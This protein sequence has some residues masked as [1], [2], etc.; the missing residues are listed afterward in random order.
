M[1]HAV[2]LV[3][4]MFRFLIVSIHLAKNVHPKDAA[5][6]HAGDTSSSAIFFVGRSSI[7]ASASAI[8]SS[9]EP[10]NSRASCVRSSSE[11]LYPEHKATPQIVRRSFSGRTVPSNNQDG[12]GRNAPCPP[13]TLSGQIER[14]RDGYARSVLER[15][16]SAVSGIAH[17]ANDPPVDSR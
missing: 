17:D 3:F 5:L 11:L 15:E 1:L 12:I 14:E 9:V 10:P 13:A 6:R 16:S 7:S 4:I 2:L 8:A